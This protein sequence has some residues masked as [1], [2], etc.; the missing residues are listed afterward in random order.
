MPCLNSIPQWHKQF[1]RQARWMRPWRLR[2]YRQAGLWQA[3]SILDVG[4]GTGTITQEIAGHTRG[5]VTGLDLDPAM[6]EEAARRVRGVEW[7]VGDAHALPFGQGQFDVVVCNFL[8]L[9]ARDPA[10]VLK[11]MTRVA[12]TGGVILDTA[13]PDYGGRIDFPEELPLGKLMSQ[14]LR[15]AGAD[16]NIGRQLRKLFVEARLTTEVGIIAS[17]WDEKQIA[18]EFE[19]EWDFLERTLDT[20]VAAQT[21]KRYKAIEKNALQAGSRFLFMPIFYALGRK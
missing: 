2:V 10:R 3:Q 15:Q 11:E 21:L 12:K 1:Q 14:A 18:E 17:L 5:S 6:I 20:V 8:L 4:C 13:E 7:K 16:P 19:G 9:W